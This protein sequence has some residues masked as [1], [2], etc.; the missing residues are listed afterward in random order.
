MKRD[1]RIVPRHYYPTKLRPLLRPGGL[2]AAHNPARPSPDPGYLKVVTADPGLETV[3]VN[4]RAA[5][6]GL[7][8]KKR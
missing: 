5:G 4:M 2:I 3:F 7:T 1:C 8:L 6:I